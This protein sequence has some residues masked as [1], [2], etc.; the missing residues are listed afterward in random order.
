[1]YFRINDLTRREVLSGVHMRSV[2][3]EG[4][5]VTFFDFEPGSI[6]PT[7]QH[8]HQ[9]IS[10]V[11]QGEAHFQLG[12]NHKRLEP[13]EGV[14]IPADTPHA[15]TVGEEPAIIWDLWVPAREDYLNPDSRSAKL[16]G[17]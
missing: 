5:M 2:A 8:P 13:G 9:Q 10:L 15:M 1:M 11:I 12:E 4:S 3:G 17:E 6:V 14:V 16:K 7:H